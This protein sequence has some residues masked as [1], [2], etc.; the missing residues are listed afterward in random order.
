MVQTDPERYVKLFRKN[1]SAFT[2][3][4]ARVH[5]AVAGMNPFAYRKPQ[6]FNLKNGRTLKVGN[7][8]LGYILTSGANL[9]PQVFANPNKFDPDR[10]NLMRHVSWNN[11]VGEFAKC[12]SPAGCPEA[13][14]G[15][16]G[17]WTALRLAIATI[18]QF[19]GALEKGGRIQRDEF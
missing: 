5:P 11:E 15:C 2:H 13:P 4:A 19:V 1:P 17:T 7:G 16:L 9:D 6:T 18:D 14:R 3:E 12:K 8:D 10:P